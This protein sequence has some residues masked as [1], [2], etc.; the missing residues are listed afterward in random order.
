MV[1]L[2]TSLGDITIELFEEQAP[3]ST[4]NFLQCVDDGFYDGTIFHRVIPGFM[5]QGGGLTTD[6]AKKPTREPIQNEADSGL[7]NRVEGMDVVDRIAAAETSTVKGCR[8]APVEPVVIE[9]ARRA[10]S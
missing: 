1:V 3:L 9:T 2:T 7:K 6:M 10:G 8:D 5:V 4:A